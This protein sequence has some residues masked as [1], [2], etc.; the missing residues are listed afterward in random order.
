MGYSPCF[1][2]IQLRISCLEG[3]VIVN[4]SF[5][6]SSEGKLELHVSEG[7]I[8]VQF[9]KFHGDAELHGRWDDGRD[10]RFFFSPK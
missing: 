6:F 5:G 3:W 1:P 4:I 2:V 9:Q 8:D 7:F 10:G